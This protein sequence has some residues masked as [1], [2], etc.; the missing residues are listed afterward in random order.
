MKNLIAFYLLA[1]IPL[2]SW[3]D[4]PPSA[5]FEQFATKFEQMTGSKVRT[6]WVG[7]I[8]NFEAFKALKLK[9]QKE[10]YEEVGRSK[11]EIEKL[12]EAD[13]LHTTDACEIDMGFQQ[14]SDRI[15]FD[16]RLIERPSEGTVSFARKFSFSNLD[17]ASVKAIFPPTGGL[18]AEQKGLRNSQSISL[19]HAEHLLIV[20]F[21]YNKTSVTC[22]LRSP[23]P[24]QR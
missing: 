7:T 4:K 1:L 2:S 15:N 16:L 10:D 13:E 9:E 22:A 3:S 24:D 14:K 12:L 17:F 8:Q 6:R 5:N 18:F 19:N 23:I 21:V 11:A 20:T